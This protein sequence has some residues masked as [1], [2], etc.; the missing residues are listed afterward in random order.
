MPRIKRCLVCEK[1]TT[2]VCAKC[3]EAAY[4]SKECQ[5]KDWRSG[6]KY[7]CAGELKLMNHLPT[8]M[9][10]PEPKWN[11]WRFSPILSDRIPET[12]W[13]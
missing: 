4:C 2:R 8:K 5:I 1:E 11:E 3:M 6:H 12:S 7:E 13:D 10:Q 9:G